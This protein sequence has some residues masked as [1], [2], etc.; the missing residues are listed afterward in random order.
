MAIYVS[1]LPYIRAVQQQIGIKDSFYVLTDPRYDFQEVMDDLRKELEI[2]S[3]VV[4]EEEE[5]YGD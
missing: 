3:Q 4:L 2:E 1:N 5:D